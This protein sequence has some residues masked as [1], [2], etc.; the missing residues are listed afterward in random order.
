MSLLAPTLE[1]FFTDRLANERHASGAT[2]T[3]YRDTFRL[4]LEFVARRRSIAPS[5]LDFADLDAPLIGAFLEYLERDRH[6]SVRTRNARLAGIHSLFRFAALRHPEHAGSIERVLSIPQKRFARTLVS[7][8][9]RAEV[10]ALLKTPDRSTW[11]G[12]R[13]H[14]LLLVAVQSGLRVSELTGLRCSDVVLSGGPHLRCCGK[15]RKERCTPLT[16]QSV[17]ILRTWVTE[18]DGAPDERLFPT[19]KGTPL[20]TDAVEWLVKK[21]ANAAVSHCPSIGTKHVTPHVL[22]HTSAMFL[23]DA[24]VD[25]SVIALWLGHQSITTTQM[26]LHADLAVK[27]RALARTAPLDTAPGRFR[28]SDTLIAFLDGL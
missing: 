24:G 25:I 23:R 6:N 1:A 8:L 18:R 4:L 26:Y 21:Y 15:G 11:I 2:V 17:A 22:R 16:S 9:S 14:A 19:R 13:D 12:R 27:E 10:E 20:S 5:N 7:F 28:P 3:A